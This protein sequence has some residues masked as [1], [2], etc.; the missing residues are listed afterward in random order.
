MSN[1]A[2]ADGDRMWTLDICL[3][4]MSGLVLYLIV[5]RLSFHDPR[6]LYNAWTYAFAVPAIA[7]V[8]ALLMR[9]V[10]TRYVQKSVQLG[11]LFSVSLHLLLLILAINVVIFSRYFPDAFSQEKRERSPV[12]HTVPEYLFQSPQQSD[13]TPDWSEPV[14]T[15]STARVIPEEQRQLPPVERTKPRLEVPQPRQPQRQTLKRFV[16]RRKRP[17][18]SQPLPADSPAKRARQQTTDQQPLSQQSPTAPSIAARAETEIASAERRLNDDSLRRSAAMQSRAQ[19]MLASSA[20]VSLN[21]PQRRAAPAAEARTRNQELPK[22]GESGFSQQRRQVTR[23]NR[24]Q[25]AGSAPAPQTVAVA[26]HSESAERMLSPVEVPMTR[27]GQTTG[28]Q[29]MAGRAA[30]SMLPSTSAATTG[31]DVARNNLAARDGMPSVTAGQSQRRP[32]SDRRTGTGSGFEAAG[33][34]PDPSA[35]QALTANAA[36]SPE[37]PQLADRLGNDDGT[38]GRSSRQG[39]RGSSPA[40]A[41]A[42]GG[43]TLD[44][45]LD[46]GPPG[47]ADRVSRNTGVTPGLEQPD[48]ASLELNPSPRPRREVGG[49]TTP[50]GAEIAAVES[51]SRRVM[52][53]QEGANPLPA[54]KVGPQTEEAIERGLAYLASIQNKDGSWSLQGDGEEVQLRS[55]SAATGLCLLAFQGAGY[56]HRQ[57][58]YADTVARGLQFLMTNQRTNGDLYRPEDAISNRNVALYSHGIAALA[59]CEAYGMTQDPELKEAAQ[60]SLNYIINTQHTKRGGWRYTPQISSDT[61]V[62]GWMMM[63]LKSGELSGLDVPERTYQGIDRWLDL[64]QSP[65]RPDRYRYNPFAPDTPT[66]RHGRL[67]TPTMT[68]VGMLMRMYSGWRREKADMQSAADYLLSAHPRMG[69]AVSP[70]RDAY[71]WYYA[72]Q[73]MFHMGGKYWEGWNRHLN[74]LLL[75]SQILHGPHTGSWDP[76]RPVPDRWSAHGGRLYVTTMN[77]LNLEVFYRHLPIYEETAE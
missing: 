5:T 16:M 14:E 13:R 51:F 61:S 1:R 69:T 42:V 71:Y 72:T 54:G 50:A 56:T 7:L 32:G 43:L 76:K 8:L 36:N 34:A 45:R 38:G 75:E 29:L 17:A 48:I 70:K 27:R 26:Q 18:E 44:M 23:A 49:P 41:D 64:A 77:L 46:D 68:S 57:H 58:Q 37:A 19:E 10:A 35:G 15:Q 30:S 20:P 40:L 62:S 2:P 59:V 31:A 67:P 3:G 9:A 74:P 63:A 21:V 39:R 25:P 73:V 52:R 60:A 6:L 11:F 28:A 12:R 53:T 47:L 22:I 24:M 66:Q 33:S 4:A 65:E 55:D